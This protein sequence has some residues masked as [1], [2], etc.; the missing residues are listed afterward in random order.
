MPRRA[1]ATPAKIRVMRCDG[2][3]QCGGEE[4]LGADPPS[5]GAIWIDLE[6][7][8]PR[9]ERLLAQWGF[10][11]LAIE[12]TFTLSPMLALVGVGIL[13]AIDDFVNARTGIGMRGRWK[14]V[15]QTV[16]ALLAAF[17]IQRHFDITQLNIPLIGTVVI[18]G[19]LFILF[20]AFVIVGVSNAVNLTDGLDGLA[21]GVLIFS[22]VAYLLIALV[23]IPEQDYAKLRSLGD[24]VAYL[25]R[26]LASP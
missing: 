3:I 16:V 22:F 7:S 6:G 21:G 10:H 18:G 12:D 19:L 25:R 20:A 14:L 17:Y 5:D 26:R 15:W 24:G 1:V 8:D 13:G 4:L 23:E 9:F 2:G 11:P